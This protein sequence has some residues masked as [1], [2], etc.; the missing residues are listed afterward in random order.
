MRRVDGHDSAWRR[1]DVM[2]WPR[3]YLPGARVA[4]GGREDR[5]GRMFWS[6]YRK[7][8]AFPWC[9]FCERCLS[10]QLGAVEKGREV[11]NVPLQ[12]FESSE[13]SLTVR[14]RQ[15][16]CLYRRSFSLISRP[17]LG[18]VL[19]GALHCFWPYGEDGEEAW[20][21]GFLWT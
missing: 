21:V 2:A 8:R 11:P 20:R 16:L 15:G 1:C 19:S 18:R 17:I 13:E 12:V 14:T 5:Y 9:E 6:K 4:H 10:R 7:R 3:Y